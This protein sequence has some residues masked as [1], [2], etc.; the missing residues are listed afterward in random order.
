MNQFS[1]QHGQLHVE[2]CASQDLAHTYG[3]P[4]YVYSRAQLTHNWQAFNQHLPKPHRACY[5]V[6]ANGNL[7]VLQVLA[8]LGAGFDVVS[9]GEI[10]RVLKAG[11]RADSIVF[12]GVAKSHAEIEYALDVGILQFNVE[13]LAELERINQIAAERGTSAPVSLRVNPDV[14]AKTHPYIAT[15][16]EANKFGIPMRD[17]VSAFKRAHSLEHVH[18]VGV[19]CHIGSQLTE[20]APFL[21][22]MDRM[23][24][25]VDE[26]AAIGIEI[27]HLDM[28]GGLGVTY[29]DETP[30]A[31]ADY[32]QA[33]LAKLDH[34]PQLALYLEPGR[35]I[36]ANAGILLTRVEYVKPSDKKDF[37]I[38]DAGMNDML[39]PSLYQAFHRIEN[40]STHQHGEAQKPCDVVGPVCETGDFLGQERKVK[41]AEGD[42]LAVFNAGAYG[43]AMSSNYNTRV[44]PAE[45]MVDGNQVHVVRQR[46][47][48]E[49]LWQL[50][51]TLEL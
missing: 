17:A 27:A 8:H 20:L 6:K 15:G 30:P 2:A 39:R 38:V 16:L 50:E 11:G 7:A 31:V 25:L 42:I 47:Q 19:D 51:R 3:T 10:A 44:R 22:A 28:G 45:I 23:L 18:V 14:D 33:M 49:Q 4:L 12:S 37:V 41:A 40:T 26:L 9:G 1:Y 35:A 13:S 24:A 5:A 48:L 29:D 46:E 43:F 36:V 21:D 34:Y 32:I